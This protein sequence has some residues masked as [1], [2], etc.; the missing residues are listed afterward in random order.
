VSADNY[1]AC[2]PQRFIP[3]IRYA[4]Q[5]L[6]NIKIRIMK[7]D[8]KSNISIKEYILRELNKNKDIFTGVSRY[9]YPV[10]PD[11]KLF[12]AKKSHNLQLKDEILWLYDTTLFG[13][14]TENV[15][16]T[17]DGLR[18]IDTF[19]GKTEIYVSW[20]KLIRVD[21]ESGDDNYYFIFDEDDETQNINFS[22]LH[23]DKKEIPAYLEL[24]N[25]IAQFVENMEITLLQ[26]I[27]NEEEK[28]NWEIIH[29]LCDNF[30]DSFPESPNTFH[31]FK[32]KA[33]AYYNTN[34][35]EKAIEF[36]DYSL[37]YFTSDERISGHRE[38]FLYLNLLLAEL[39]DK[40]KKYGSL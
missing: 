27:W 22:G 4:L 7:T 24:L 5:K 35:I 12:N 14:A 28:K 15:I 38:S 32:A 11:K 29:E 3:P 17:E 6:T 39:L 18:K 2:N 36:I 34:N 8:N 26:Q 19:L 37:E 21:Y 31:A 33:Q 40:Q 20:E 9:I 10:F 13:S 1:E 25:N 16:I 30:V 23:F